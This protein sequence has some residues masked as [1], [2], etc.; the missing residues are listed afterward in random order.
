MQPTHYTDVEGGNW[1]AWPV[2]VWLF[3]D[4]LDKR[5]RNRGANAAICYLLAR[6][7]IKIHALRFNQPRMRWDCINGFTGPPLCP[8]A[9]HYAVGAG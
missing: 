4:F 8:K 9:N 5:A 7:A 2:G 3:Q 1:I 6:P